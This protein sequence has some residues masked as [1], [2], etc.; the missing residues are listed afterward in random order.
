[1][2]LGTC[3]PLTVWVPKGP[4]NGCQEFREGVEHGPISQHCVP[5]RCRDLDSAS[6]A[7]VP[8][9]RS[10]CPGCDRAPQGRVLLKVMV[11]ILQVRR[12]SLPAGLTAQA[13]QGDTRHTRSQLGR[14][15]RARVSEP[16]PHARAA[17][18]GRLARPRFGVPGSTSATT[19]GRSWRRRASAPCPTSSSVNSRPL[20]PAPFPTA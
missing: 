6:P 1:M 13:G 3:H 15:H 16:S 19:E 11:C 14:R 9:Q 17:Q 10:R 4:L 7:R 2:Q 8:D 5:S 18:R 12:P 20:S